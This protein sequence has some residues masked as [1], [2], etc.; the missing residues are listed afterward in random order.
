MNRPGRMPTGISTIEHGE[1]NRVSSSP[2]VTKAFPGPE[3]PFVLLGATGL[4]DGQ[5]GCMAW[6]H[7]LSGRSRIRLPDNAL[8]LGLRASAVI[9]HTVAVWPPL[10]FPSRGRPGFRIDVRSRRLSIF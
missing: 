7:E 6:S 1:A 10:D 8:V 4:Q 3:H 2:G 5:A 9:L